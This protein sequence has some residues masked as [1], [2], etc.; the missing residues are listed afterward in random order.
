[1]ARLNLPSPARTVRKGVQVCRRMGLDGEQGYEMI[2]AVCYAAVRKIDGPG[3]IDV[4]W[5][6]GVHEEARCQLL[7]LRQ[8]P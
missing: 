1:M 7:R 4:T 5:L 2:M 6:A 8:R 3:D